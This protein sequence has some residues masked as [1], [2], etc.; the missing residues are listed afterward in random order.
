MLHACT[1][2]PLFRKT[3]QGIDVEPYTI[4]TGPQDWVGRNA[5]RPSWPAPPDDCNTIL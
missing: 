2:S 3:T 5:A 4:V 1:H